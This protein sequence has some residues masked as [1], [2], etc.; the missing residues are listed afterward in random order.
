MNAL[1]NITCAAV[2]TARSESRRSWERNVENHALPI[3]GAG[4]MKT[5]AALLLALA[6]CVRVCGRATPT[7]PPHKERSQAGSVTGA[8]LQSGT[9]QGP[10]P[11]FD[12]TDPAWGA[13]C[14]SVTDDTTAIQAALTAANSGSHGGTVFIPSG[15]VAGTCNFANPLV[16]DNFTNVSMVSGTRGAFPGLAGGRVN[17]KYTGT[18]SPGISARNCFGCTFDGIYLQASNPGMTGTVLNFSG[19]GGNETVN[20]QFIN[21]AITGPSSG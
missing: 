18:T 7:Q 1:A 6:L 3:K 21:G 17:L 15:G 4:P 12:V 20:S 9:F 8:A 5:T 2:L 10:N 11:W 13:K 14:D 16:M 19:S